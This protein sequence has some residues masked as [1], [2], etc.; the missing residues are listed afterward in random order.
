MVD[1]GSIARLAYYC[2][3]VKSN[4]IVYIVAFYI[5]VDGNPEI[6]KFLSVNTS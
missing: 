5:M 2:Y 4:L 3:D 6:S 1:S